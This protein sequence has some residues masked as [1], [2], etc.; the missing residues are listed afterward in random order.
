MSTVGL[1]GAHGA[2]MTG[3][4]GIGVNTPIAA[5]VAE[6]TVGFAIEEHMPNGIIFFIG[7]LSI[8]VAMGIDETTLLFGKTF[9]VDGAAPKLQHNVAPAQTQNPICI[10]PFI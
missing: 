7:T 6:A 5:A 2:V 4:H 3:V 10:P 9:S 1:P 8:I